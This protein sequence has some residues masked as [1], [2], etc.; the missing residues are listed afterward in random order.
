M[1]GVHACTLTPNPGTGVQPRGHNGNVLKRLFSFRL[2]EPLTCHLIC[3]KSNKDIS[4]HIMKSIYW[5]TGSSICCVKLMHWIIQDYLIHILPF[6]IDH[7][8]NNTG[9]HWITAL[10]CEFVNTAL[11]PPMH[12]KIWSRQTFSCSDG[13]RWFPMAAD[14]VEWSKIIGNLLGENLITCLECF[15]NFMLTSCCSNIVSG[16]FLVATDWLVFDYQGLMR[17]HLSPC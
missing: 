13:A 15:L 1:L 10:L 6:V 3:L 12:P 9:R 11:M 4:V 16:C 17:W 14:Y 7:I 5:H 8:I 2:Y